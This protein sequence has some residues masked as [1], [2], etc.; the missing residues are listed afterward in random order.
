MIN[1]NKVMQLR[2][3]QYRSHRFPPL[4]EAVPQPVAPPRVEPKVDTNADEFDFDGFDTSF[5]DNDF[6]IDGLGLDDF[7]Q[8]DAL[9]LN[10]LGL[11]EFE[12]AEEQEESSDAAPTPSVEDYQTQFNQGFQDGVARG[13]EEGIKQ[14]LIQ[15]KEQGYEEGLTLGQE[16]GFAKA[17]QEGLAQFKKAS[18]PFEVMTQRLQA[19]FQVHERRQREQVC[20]LVQKVAQQVIRGELA[21]QPQQILALVEETL[22]TM[23]GEPDGLK[24]AM[25]P[26]EYQHIKQIAPEKIQEWNIVCDDSLRQGDCKVVTK[27]AE[28]DA[29]CHQRLEVCMENVR[30]NLLDDELVDDASLLLDDLAMDEGISSDR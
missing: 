11:D 1:R 29:G 27:N 10:D 6:A 23:P 12:Q 13:H 15:G 26:D 7:S 25:A 5:D 14:G 18:Q 16:H 17:Q 8:D 20:E 9:D 3:H 4:I 19:L 28:A 30:T 2:P 21:L 22:T 24:V